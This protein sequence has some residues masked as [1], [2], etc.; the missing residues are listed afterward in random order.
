[1]TEPVI[2]APVR[3]LENR[4]ALQWL[5][6]GW[7][8]MAR[9][10]GPSL[11]H[12]VVFLLAGA[13]IAAVGWGR[14]D[15]LAGAF[16]GFLLVA[17]MLAAGLYEVSRRLARGEHPTVRDVLAVWVQG[18]GCMV[19]L[20]LLLAL[21]GTLW[22][23]LSLL[24]VSAAVGE[25]GGGVERFLR[26]FVLAPDP[27]PFALWLAAGGVFAALVFAIGAVSVPMLLDRE[28]NMLTAVLTSVRAVGENP[29]AMGVWAA[30]VMLLTLVGL[31][32]GV[33]LVVLVPLLG[34]ATWHAYTDTVDAALLPPRA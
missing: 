18:G 20:G 4:R 31:A 30:L 26:G 15:L 22:V 13:A 6:L 33:G 19:R 7:Q 16:S 1:M 14:H 17:P 21:L 34:H 12:G 27:L 5:A 28:V 10:P 29:A 11:L 32:T 23:G 9:A 3:L 24:I 2:A 25:G 8:D